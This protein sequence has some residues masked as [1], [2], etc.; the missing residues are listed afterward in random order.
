MTTG[1]ESPTQTM[2]R[3]SSGFLLERALYA[4]TKLDIADHLKEG[5]KSAGE[6]AKLVG[7]DPNILHRL[8]RAVAGMGVFHQDEEGAFSLTHLGETLRSDVDASMRSYVLFCHEFIYPSMGAII[9]SSKSATPGFDEVFGIPFYQFT[10][11]NDEAAHLFNDLINAN[12]RFVVPALMTAYD[13]SDCGRVVDLGGEPAL[14]CRRYSRPMKRS[15]EYCSTFLPPFKLRK[16]VPA[17]R[18]RAVNWCLAF[19]SPT[20][21]PMETPLF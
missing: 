19:F 3:L 2:I 7:V 10:K 4:V 21:Y 18:Y 14:S 9:S 17:V 16:A 5:H 6:L 1:T 15:R 12:S 20:R 13:F 8:M 11:E